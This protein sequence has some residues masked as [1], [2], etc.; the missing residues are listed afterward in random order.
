MQELINA[1]GSFEAGNWRQAEEWYRRVVEADP[2]NGEALYRLGLLALEGNDPAAA[3]EWLQKAAALGQRRC[4]AATTNWVSHGRKLK[5]FEEAIVCF[6]PG[7]EL[8]R[9]AATRSTTGA[10]P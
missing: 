6:Q 2:E 1:R 8:D 3:A 9:P 4:R 5:Q 10:M 7:G